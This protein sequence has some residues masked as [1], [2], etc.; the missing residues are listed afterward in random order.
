MAILY[1]S[2]VCLLH[3][4]LCYLWVCINRVILLLARETG[5]VIIGYQYWLKKQTNNNPRKWRPNKI[6]W[7]LRSITPLHLENYCACNP[8][9]FKMLSQEGQY[10]E[11]FASKPKLKHG[12]IQSS[13][14][15]LA[16]FA[17]LLFNLTLAFE[18]N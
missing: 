17:F 9:H 13:S 12:S 1:S 2:V 11:G 7:F 6:T 10:K 3:F 14:L 8:F 18:I 15:K 5:S 16:S 4:N